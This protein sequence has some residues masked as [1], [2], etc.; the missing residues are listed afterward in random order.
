VVITLTI[1]ARP[2]EESAPP[3]A[4]I[5]TAEPQPVE[6]PTGQV[7]PTPRPT[8]RP[9]P[10][11]GGAPGPRLT[12]APGSA[13]GPRLTPAPGLRP[14]PGVSPGQVRRTRIQ[15]LVPEGGPQ[16]VRIVVIDETGVRTIYQA[17]HSPG[18]RIDQVVQSQ[19]YTII[20]VYIANRLVQEVRP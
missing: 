11:P 8:A 12:P 17:Q 10:A 14:T 20:Q 3:R 7:L 4:P 9:T 15:V 13:P 19:G 18:D 2:G 16:E 5:I 1:S 6:S